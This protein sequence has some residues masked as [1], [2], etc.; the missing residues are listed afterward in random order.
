MQVCILRQATAVPT[1]IYN[2]PRSSGSF[3]IQQIH[4]SPLLIPVLQF[5]YVLQEHLA[6]SSISQL[7][8]ALTAS[9]YCQYIALALKGSQRRICWKLGQTHPQYYTATGFTF[10]N[11][12]PESSRPPDIYVVCCFVPNGKKNLEYNLTSLPTREIFQLNGLFHQKVSQTRSHPWQC[13]PALFLPGHTYGM[14]FVHHIGVSRVAG[15]TNAAP[16]LR[17]QKGRHSPHLP[18]GHAQQHST[19]GVWSCLTELVTF[20]AVPSDVCFP[21]KTV[22]QTL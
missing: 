9:I 18:R 11:I 8:P 4:I 13:V 1:S 19:H 12:S 17:G 10:T 3:H 2:N 21:K 14:I 5:L 7:S 6:A 16:E 20:S 15:F 22:S